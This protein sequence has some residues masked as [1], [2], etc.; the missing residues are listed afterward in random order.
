MFRLTVKNLRAN[1]IRFALTTFG[2]V[3]AVSFV[4]SAWVLG[5][6]LRST[7]T[8]VS[9]E[10]TAGVDLQVRPV[11]DFGDPEPLP[12][13]V[14]DAVSAI[15]GVAD[16]VPSIEAAADAVRPLTA[17]GDA[18]TTGGPPHL[19]FNWI[20]NEELSP[21]SLVQGSPPTVGEFVLDR[22]S[23]ADHGFVIGNTYELLTPGG[24]AELTLSGT[25]SFGEDNA[26]LGAV[27]MQM[28]TAQA[29]ELFG[30][31][32]ISTVDVQL[33][34]GADPTTVQAAVAA[35]VPDAEVVDH[36]V[37]L[38]ETTSDFTTEIDVVRNILLGFGGV[39]LFVSIFIVYNTFAIV[40][41][42]RT[43]ELALLRTLG[44]DPRQ[45]RRTV[46]GEALVIGI[47]A[48]AAGILGGIAVAKGIDALFAVMG[49]DLSEWPLIL[50]P[51]TIVT[52][53]VVGL[54]VTLL[55]ARGPARRA[56]TVPAMAALRGGDAPGSVG[57]RSRK[58]AALALIGVG[59]LAGAAGL[60]GVGPTATTVLCM[61]VGAIGVFL[62][63]TLA[64]PMLVGPVTGV[65]GLPLR[66]LAPVTGKLARR[67]AAR[68]PRRT[69][70]TA[71]A[72]MIGL[73]LVSTALVVGQSVKA[74][75]GGTIEESAKAEYFVT[76]QLEDV[77]FPT[78]LADE[79]GSVAVV[80]A[81]SGFRYVEARVDGT[82]TDVVAADLGALDRVLDL[83]VRG[84]GAGAVTAHPVLVSAEAAGRGVSVG[85]AV[86]VEF[87]NGSR[88][89]ST[90][91]GVFHD[92]AIIGED[93]LF[94][95][96]T[97]D[98]AG[99]DEGD[100]WLAVSVVDGADPVAVEALVSEVS[101]GFP[102]ADVETAAEYRE[103][104]A[105]MVDQVLAMVNVM[106]GL[107]VVIAL[108]GI[109]NTLALS[110][111]E[112]TRELGLIRAVGMSRRQLRRMVRYEAALIAA[113]G[114]VLGVGV[115][116]VFGWA[117]VN[118]LP[119]SLIGGMAVPVGPIVTVTA[120]AALAGV[121]AAWLPA[122]RAGRLD[123]LEAI[124]H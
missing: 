107:A 99:V 45:V 121:V 8:G 33:A 80:D 122:R 123:V 55:A 76:D 113:F 9:E 105:G 28:S 54:G 117:I 112:R 74:H 1:K 42:Q 24:R 59:A 118:A 40:V 31:D 35:A 71:G 12:A 58:T 14:V 75:L 41:G 70:T 81:V 47:L 46:M 11:S 68:N 93:Y 20:E 32:G 92:E 108:I 5:D 50:A 102:D 17:V 53:L 110:V 109:A 23:A 83:D 16:A 39:A 98:E 124:A 66:V 4:V 120:V 27:L 96:A 19:A 115:G 91:T 95:T 89:E 36:S 116:L 106:I 94:D 103:R 10:I 13:G 25:S 22:D 61:A 38:D 104:L 7:F 114:A 69:A 65:L 56:S 49:V 26:T 60:A 21:F 43:R 100:D 51:R 82:V 44:A 78:S 63:V 73:A 18:I 85:D 77:A 88:A 67:N 48:S 90:V 2:V 79:I 3:L 86:T 6:G 84:G 111:F 57:R 29:G 97:F 62:G 52:A 72:L 15:D 119:D 101:G 64:S 37:V 34:D 87:A 30:I